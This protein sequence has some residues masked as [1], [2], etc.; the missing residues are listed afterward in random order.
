MQFDGVEPPSRTVPLR[1]REVFAKPRSG[2]AQEF[3]E[4]ENA[5]DEDLSTE[6]LRIATP[7][8]S[9]ALPSATIPP[10]A[11]AVVV[12]AAFD[13]RGGDRGSD[14]A[15]APGAI[16]L[17]L[18]GTLAGHGL[19]DRGADVW[20]ADADGQPVTRAPTGNPLLAPRLGVSV[21]R[22]DPRMSEDD[23]ASWTY[24]AADGS[25]PGAPDRLR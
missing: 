6:G 23:P 13:P 4:I 8:G 21:V 5:G 20:I 19:A 16:V 2:S 1:I 24:D 12:G 14:A 17:R 9:A 18:E 10:R 15:T 25:T 11:R 22:A 3:V 7:T